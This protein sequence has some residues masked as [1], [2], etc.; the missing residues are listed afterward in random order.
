MSRQVAKHQCLVRS[1]TDRREADAQCLIGE[2]GPDDGV[3]GFGGELMGMRS[4]PYRGAGVLSMSE[5]E[6]KWGKVCWQRGSRRI[7]EENV[8]KMTREVNG[9]R[10]RV[11]IYSRC[12][13]E[14]AMR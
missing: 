9:A 5:W 4:K 7:K 2:D 13:M 12:C 6:G 11:R 3:S 14:D 1:V 10:G 8:G